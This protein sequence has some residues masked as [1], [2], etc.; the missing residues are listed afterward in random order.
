MFIAGKIYV[1]VVGAKARSRDVWIADQRD[2]SSRRGRGGITARL[3]Q[4]PWAIFASVFAEHGATN[5]TSA[6]R[7]SS[8]CKIGSPILYVG[9]SRITSVSG[10]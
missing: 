9:C 6:H 8:I 7:R 2:T 10:H 3:S 4:V 1:G 5:T